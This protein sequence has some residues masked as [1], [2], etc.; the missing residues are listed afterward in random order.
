MNPYFTADRWIDLLQRLGRRGENFV[1]LT[2][3]QRLAG[4]EDSATRK[5]LRRLEQKGYLTR[6]GKS[7]YANRFARP[8]LEELAVLLGRPCYVSCE[9]ALERYGVLSQMPMVLTC[10]STARSERRETPLGE[11]VFHR[12][13]PTLF[14]G[15]HSEDGI[16]WA[17]P[18]KALLDWLY[19]KRKTRGASPALDEL[20]L[21]RLDRAKLMEW[22]GRY[23]GSLSTAL[24][25]DARFR[26]VDNDTA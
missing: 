3:L 13:P 7:L 15:Y 23:P 14:F 18:E 10:V 9:S 26:L 8:T 16:L 24:R 2:A 11:I 6:V 1:T 17:D 21:E 4:L 12:L 19:I 5:S 20:D 22:A 25:L